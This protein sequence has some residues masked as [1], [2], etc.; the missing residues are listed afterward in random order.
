MGE[1][2]GRETIVLRRHISYAANIRDTEIHDKVD[3]S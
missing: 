1:K 3:E 2:G